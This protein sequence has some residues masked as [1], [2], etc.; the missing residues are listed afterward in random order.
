[1]VFDELFLLLGIYGNE[2]FFFKVLLLLRVMFLQQV[3]KK[4]FFFCFPV[5]GAWRSACLLHCPGLLISAQWKMPF[6]PWG[7][8]CRFCLRAPPLWEN[9]I[10]DVVM[11]PWGPGASPV[12]RHSVALPEISQWFLLARG[13]VEG[14][15][16]EKD[17]QR[18]SWCD[19]G[20][21]L[22]PVMSTARPQLHLLCISTLI[23][24]ISCS[25]FLPLKRSFSNTRAV[26][27]G[28]W[29]SHL[30]LHYFLGFVASYGRVGGGDQAPWLCVLPGSGSC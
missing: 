8:G 12:D 22:L 3:D 30:L 20:F 17:V 18:G 28:V 23:I 14:G 7:G 26:D 6:L 15:R 2:L 1:M 27:T 9:V 16:G 10:G 4:S 13:S 21:V 5:G 11:N 29:A 19:C 25:A 24:E